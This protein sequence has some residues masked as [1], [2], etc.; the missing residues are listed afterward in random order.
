MSIFC[1]LMLPLARTLCR[2]LAVIACGVCLGAFSGPSVPPLLLF[3]DEI[4][5][6]SESAPGE[7]LVEELREANALEDEEDDL[8]D[9]GGKLFTKPSYSLNGL[10]NHMC[11]RIA[12]H[13][14][15]RAIPSGM[16]E[17]DPRPPRTT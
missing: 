11:A 7:D 16:A 10:R 8:R 2:L 17:L 13:A 9:E 1:T 5:Q 15:T 3:G 12:T 14:D 4:Q 6:G